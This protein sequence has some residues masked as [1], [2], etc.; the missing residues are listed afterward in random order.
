MRKKSKIVIIQDDR[1][2]NMQIVADLNELGIEFEPRRL[3]T[4]DYVFGNVLVERK[5]IDDFCASIMDKRLEGQIE[6]MKQ[7]GKE[8]FII[9]V[10]GIN[11]RTSEINENCLLGKMV[12]IVFR[13]NIKMLF[14]E[15]ELQFCFVLKNLCEKYSLR[16]EGKE[17][18]GGMR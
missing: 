14:V 13:H 9:V 2:P 10:G 4:G 3:S 1:E 7:S 11:D 12:S 15:D 16:E 8:C 18:K 6:K 5:T 17:M